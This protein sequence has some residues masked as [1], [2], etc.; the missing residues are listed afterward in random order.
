MLQDDFA[1][2]F[3]I[4]ST[5]GAQQADFGNLV[6]VIT[7]KQS[8]ST[9]TECAAKARNTLGHNLVWAAQSLDRNTYDLLAHN[10]ATAC[11]HAIAKLY[12]RLP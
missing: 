8:I 6:Q 12:A 5:F 3:D 9:A 2:E 7:P 4:S 11:L 10:I 1:T